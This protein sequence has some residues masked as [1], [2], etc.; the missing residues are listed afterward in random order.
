MDQKIYFARLIN[1]MQGGIFYL[2]FE[3]KYD[4][5]KILSFDS[6]SPAKTKLFFT[7]FRHKDP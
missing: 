2:Y 4:H 3:L 6:D 5:E 7:E 1:Q